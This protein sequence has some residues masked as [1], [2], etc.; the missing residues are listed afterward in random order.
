M[1][2]YNNKKDAGGVIR[3]KGGGF[4]L[5]LREEGHRLTRQRQLVLD[6]LTSVPRSVADIA[7]SLRRKKGSIDRVTIYRTLN[8][9]VGL[10]LAAKTRFKDKVAKYELVSDVP[11]HHHLVCDR[12]G[13]V[14]DITLDHS[15]LMAEVS[16]RT[17]F[18]VLGH[19]LEFFGLCVKCQSGTVEN[20]ATAAKGHLK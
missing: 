1:A 19:S 8:C 11:H 12:C 15:L 9:L 18:K 7:S 10:G 14:E 3:G 16:K 2:S 6:E 17:D 13:A 5:R 20:K 4:S